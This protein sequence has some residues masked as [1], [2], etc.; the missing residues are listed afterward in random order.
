MKL[1]I[2]SILVVA[3]GIAVNGI[4]DILLSKQKSN[5]MQY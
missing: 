2:L 1:A 5:K 4:F 3:A